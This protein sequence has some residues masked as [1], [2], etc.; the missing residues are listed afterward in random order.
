MGARSLVLGLAILGILAGPSVAHGQDPLEL[1]P[2]NYS[3]L[4]ENDAVRVLDFRLARGATEAF[5]EHPANVAV[6]LSEFTIQFTFPDGSTG[7][8]E[9][10]PGVASYSG[11]VVHASANV[12]DTDAHG[13]IVELKDGASRVGSSDA[14]GAAG[15]RVAGSPVTA[16]TLIHGLPG[17]EDELRD[18]LVSLA[19][20]TRAEPGAIAYDLYQSPDRRNEFL[21]FE[22]WESLDA[23]EAHKRA[24]HIQASF[25]RRQREG[26]TTEIVLWE[27]VP[28]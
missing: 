17:Q 10:H 28:E 16:F 1:Y 4:F 26:W 20:P 8:R 27:R 6:F 23:L 5:H 25:E 19:A 13:I 11:P 9:G 22:M 15:R 21:R 3:V 12:G 2:D 18:H 7:L 24:P 14:G